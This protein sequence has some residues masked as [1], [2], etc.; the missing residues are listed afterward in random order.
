M[1]R[2][3]AFA[4]VTQVQSLVGELRSHKE[5]RSRKLCGMAQTNKKQTKNVW[6]EETTENQEE[7]P[8][9]LFFLFWTFI[10]I[11]LFI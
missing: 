10:F 9:F 4:A 3:C 2:T 1:V 11:Y 7:E 8:S 5:I 6:G